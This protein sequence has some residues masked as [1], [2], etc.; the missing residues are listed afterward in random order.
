MDEIGAPQAAATQDPE[1]PIPG[2]AGDPP[3]EPV[4]WSP[5]P[6]DSGRLSVL[7]RIETSINSSFAELHRE[8]REKAALDR[9]REDQIDRLHA[10]LQ[11]YRNDL[12]TKVARQLMQ[13]LVRLHDDL[14]RA[15]AGL[16][17]KPLAELT[18][19]T[20]FCQ[21]ADFQDDVELLLGQHGV[22]RFEGVGEAFDPR[23]QTVVRKVPTDDPNWVGL[24]AERVRPG[25]EQ[26]ETL[27][28]RERV[29]V[30]VA[31]NGANPQE[32]GGNS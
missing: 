1:L 32:K 5:S 9:F 12:V 7:E 3:P 24:V 30:F 28:Q 8:I 26:G 17:L 21:L 10:E 4:G 6:P 23:R 16:R 31:S 22:E 15:A 27:L 14:A 2:A 13:G 19:E 25:F 29:A 18:P 11:T 20:L